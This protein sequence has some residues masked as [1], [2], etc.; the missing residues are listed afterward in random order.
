[1]EEPLQLVVRYLQEVSDNSDEVS[2]LIADGSP[3][4]AIKAGYK[5]M[6]SLL[7]A[8]VHLRI[9]GVGDER[10]VFATESQLERNSVT[11]HINHLR[12]K[13]ISQIIEACI[14]VGDSARLSEVLQLAKSRVLAASTFKRNLLDTVKNRD[15]ICVKGDP[16]AISTPNTY[17]LTDVPAEEAL[18]SIAPK[19][20]PFAL[21][22]LCFCERLTE[23]HCVVASLIDGQYR[24][25]LIRLCDSAETSSLRQCTSLWLTATHRKQEANLLQQILCQLGKVFTQTIEYMASLGIEKVLLIPHRWL[26]LLPWHATHTV[27][28]PTPLA[29]RFSVVSY[30]NNIMQ[31][32]QTLRLPDGFR[33]SEPAMIGMVDTKRTLCGWPMALELSGCWKGH[34]K[35]FGEFRRCDFLDTLAVHANIQLM[36]FFGHGLCNLRDY[37]KGGLLAEDGI[38]TFADLVSCGGGG[39]MFIAMLFA[40][41]SGRNGY[42][43]EIGDEYYAIDGAFLF[44]GAVHVFSSLWPVSDVATFLLGMRIIRGLSDNPDAPPARLLAE[45]VRW[46]RTGE[47]FLERDRYVSRLY[48]KKA[49]DA[50]PSLGR[51][52]AA[53]EE[54]YWNCVSDLSADCFADPVYWAAWRCVGHGGEEPR[55]KD[56][57]APQWVAA[58]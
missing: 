58:E 11:D 18:R 34:K 17:V 28:D 8:E 33:P 30:A 25:R 50:A 43:E 3:A 2:R 42:P 4:M 45:A 52:I 41:E 57:S 40:C 47:W 53:T 12:Q 23:I 49:R 36:A 44:R 32:E 51:E 16:N 9:Y 10:F 24:S 19:D 22:D 15:S 7:S 1:M 39:K 6:V 5:Q 48:F 55:G 35:V 56:G 26:H 54:R 46:L 38:V 37:S 20:S 27:L 21:V 31:Y 29:E 13:L 14:H